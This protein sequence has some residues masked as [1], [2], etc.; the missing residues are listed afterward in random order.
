MP[1]PEVLVEMD[2]EKNIRW[3]TVRGRHYPF[4]GA[5]YP[6]HTEPDGFG[7]EASPDHPHW[8]RVLFHEYSYDCSREENRLVPAYPKMT[9]SYPASPASESRPGLCPE[10]VDWEA[11]RAFL[12]SL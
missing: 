7:E 5:E 10:S 9:E 11:H 1:H 4:F 8:D 3:Y 2:L 6:L 12:R